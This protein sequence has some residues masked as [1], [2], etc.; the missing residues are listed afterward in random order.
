[1]KN[2]GDVFTFPFFVLFFKIN[3]GYFDFCI[4]NVINITVTNEFLNIKL[5]K[6]KK[7]TFQIIAFVLLCLLIATADSWF[8]F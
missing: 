7:T 1:V 3:I 4:D 8:N 2:T 6:M 5:I